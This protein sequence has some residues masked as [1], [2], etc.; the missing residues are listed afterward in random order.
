MYLHAN[1]R[2]CRIADWLKPS[3]RMSSN[4]A[5]ADDLETKDSRLP[6]FSY[7]FSLCELYCGLIAVFMCGLTI[8]F[9]FLFGAMSQIPV[10]LAPG[11]QDQLINLLYALIVAGFSFAFGASI[12]II[13]CCSKVVD[14]FHSGTGSVV[15]EVRPRRYIQLIPLLI[16][17]RAQNVSPLLSIP[18]G[19]LWLVYFLLALF[20]R[21]GISEFYN[22]FDL[23][24]LADAF[25]IAATYLGFVFACNIYLGLAIG[26][27]FRNRFITR[28]IWRSRFAFD[29][30]VVMFAAL[31]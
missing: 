14:R 20:A 13:R 21:H 15:G 22:G 19:L 12:W 5:F 2:V 18:L 17:H 29:F 27:L 9:V 8:P 24:P 28:L 10:N 1:L 11:N 26:A 3:S 4:L 25:M 7:V 31:G 23:S 16:V 6:W 30:L